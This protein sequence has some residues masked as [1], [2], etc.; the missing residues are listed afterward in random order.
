MSVMTRSAFIQSSSVFLV[1]LSLFGC[2]QFSWSETK[3]RYPRALTD[4][5][6]RT[7]YPVR[8]LQLALSASDRRYVV[9]ASEYRMPQGRALLNLKHGSTLDV[10]WSMTS[11]DRERLLHPIRIPIYKGLIGWRLLLIRQQDQKKFSQLEHVT[12][13]TKLAAVQG[14]DWP[15]TAIL[16][17]NGFLVQGA[18]NYQGMFDM[19]ARGR[20]DYFPRSIVE[21]WQE[22][23]NHRNK[24]LV[25]ETTLLMHYPT[26]FY[27]FVNK[28]NRLLAEDLE[29]GLRRIIANSE[30]DRLFSTY[31][32]PIMDK[33]RIDQRRLVELDNPTLPAETPLGQSRL[34]LDIPPDL[35][36]WLE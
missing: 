26:A 8:L 25:V 11:K 2:C 29:A 20:A 30:F 21:I 34:W 12:E 10:V 14:H 23:N 32:D 28:N 3:V 7:E 16:E 22:Q 9:E 31:F 33:A 19:L 35:P 18:S 36:K 4:N 27:Y 15:D 6:K 5:D 13:L 1:F 17:S 24:Q